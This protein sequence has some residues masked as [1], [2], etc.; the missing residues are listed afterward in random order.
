M[1]VQ[2]LP[3]QLQWL[4][5]SDEPLLGV[6]A[7][8]SSGKTRVG[9]I[10]VAQ[11]LCLGENC[12]VGAQ[13]F[14]ALTKVI[15]SEIRAVLNSWRV[16]FD[17]NKTDKTIQLGN[18][19]IAHGYTYENASGILG[20]S[21]IHNLLC[22]EIFYGTEDAFNFAADRLRGEHIKQSKIRIIGSPDNQNAVHAWA[23]AMARRMENEGLLIYAS[24]LENSFTSETFKKNLLDRYP[25]GTPL[26]EQQI[27]GHLI[28]ADIANAII[29]KSDF[30]TF[31]RIGGNTG[32][33]SMGIDLASTGGDDTVFIVCNNNRIIDK[34]KSNQLNSFQKLTT[35][36]ELIARHNVTDIA[37]DTTGGFGDFIVDE[38]RAAGHN[39][40]G[41]NFG[42]A[43][44]NI[45]DE[46]V[47][48]SMYF[49]G[50]NDIRNGF[51]TDDTDLVQELTSTQYTISKRGKLG[52]VPKE[53]I[54]QLLGRSPDT[55]D[56][57]VLARW[58]AKL[59]V[60]TAIDNQLT[61]RV[62]A[63]ALNLLN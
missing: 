60:D 46:N 8:V 7:G 14:P 44:D 32:V 58:A 22:D 62:A 21:N 26:Y 39:V 17:Y 3:W 11:R 48:T 33:V 55:A 34:V 30:P 27:C 1:R 28:D 24:A 4:K 59:H 19:A 50:T 56:A 42:G 41:V 36:K 61:N 23:I 10:W 37:I 15:F 20:L 31:C 63:R 57:F 49:N 6:S 54:R 51:Y 47:R 9:A 45:N 12:L 18:G 35:A 13:T 38:L 16:P 29:K 40:T 53:K 2:L 43:S 52:L 5:R 25:I